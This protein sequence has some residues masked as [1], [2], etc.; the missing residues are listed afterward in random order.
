MCAQRSQRLK[1]HACTSAPEGENCSICRKPWQHA[2]AAT[3]TGCRWLQVRAVP[4]L[5]L[6]V[7]DPSAAECSWAN[8]WAEAWGSESDLCVFA[9]LSHPQVIGAGGLQGI[10][11]GNH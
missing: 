2:L 1:A 11:S 9:L 10:S 5:G 6:V 3:L 7:G 8:A 4:W